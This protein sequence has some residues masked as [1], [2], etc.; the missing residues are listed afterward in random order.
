[1][2][3]Y[4]VYIRMST[5]GEQPFFENRSS[6]EAVITALIA[7]QLDGW[8]RLHGFIVL[9]EALEMVVSP[10]RQSASGLA[11]HLQSETIPVL[12]VLQPD[13][14]L[15]WAMRHVEIPLT[16][17]RA[18][19]ARLQMM[20]LAPIAYGLA[21]RAEDYPYS[22]A[23]PRYHASASI[24]SGFAMLLSKE[25]ALAAEVKLRIVSEPLKRLG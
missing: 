12:T 18:L 19:D 5:E 9:P 20:L 13:A 15:V 22:S 2:L 17:E 3:E 24:Y 25:D 8:M 16:S 6:A 21:D 11:A 23:S 10:I 1:M 4:P 14:G 7:A